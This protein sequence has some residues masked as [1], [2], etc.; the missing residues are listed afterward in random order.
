MMFSGFTRLCDVYACDSSI[1]EF[2]CSPPPPASSASCVA[3]A[4]SKDAPLS[5][6]QQQHNNVP[7][8]QGVPCQ[9][10]AL[11]ANHKKKKCF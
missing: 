7:A 6:Q 4:T 8:G 11:H 9:R 2:P 3:C 5:R 1:V 10:C